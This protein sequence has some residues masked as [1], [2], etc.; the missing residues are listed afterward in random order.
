MRKR[1]STRRRMRVVSACARESRPLLTS[2][3]LGWFLQVTGVRL[4]DAPVIDETAE[5]NVREA[6]NGARAPYPSVLMNPQ[7]VPSAYKATISLIFRKLDV[8]LD[9]IL[10]ST[11]V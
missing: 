5:D 8:K 3:F 11:D 4:D 6:K 2:E 1:Q 10:T 7:T 9:S